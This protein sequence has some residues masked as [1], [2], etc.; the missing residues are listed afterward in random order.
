MSLVSI[1]AFWSVEV[2]FEDSVI[3]HDLSIHELCFSIN[4]RRKGN[5][6]CWISA[7]SQEMRSEGRMAKADKEGHP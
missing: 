4:N 5:I 1:L 7:R 6:G 2:F 3:C